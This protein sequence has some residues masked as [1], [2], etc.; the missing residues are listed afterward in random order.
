MNHTPRSTGAARYSPPGEG[1]PVPIRR[2]RTLVKVPASDTGRRYSLLE[3][4]LDPETL[5]MPMHRHQGETKTFYAIEGSL[6]VQIEREVFVAMPG[7]SIVIPAG[8]MHTMWNETDRRVRFLSI[9]APGG[10]EEYYA[11]VASY[12]PTGGKPDMDRVLEASARFGIEL[13][14]LSLLDIIERHQV[15]LA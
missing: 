15:Q 9:V 14:M 6:T 13:D 7:A 8:T 3:H 2:F 12:I 5:A 10:L 4:A 1:A 11:E